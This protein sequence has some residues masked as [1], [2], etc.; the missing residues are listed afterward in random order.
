VRLL[1]TRANGGPALVA[2]Q[3]DRDS[4]A[5]V[6][7][8]VHLFDVRGDRLATITAFLDPRLVAA[9]GLPTTLPAS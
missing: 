1:P 3:R 4:G 7:M 5:F 8:G 9:F 2:Y 6:A